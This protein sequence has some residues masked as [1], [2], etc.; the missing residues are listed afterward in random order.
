MT[1][2]H[3]ETSYIAPQWPAPE[4]IKAF[5]STRQHGH[6]KK[7]FD[8]FNLAFHVKDSPQHVV[9]N[10]D[11]LRHD[12]ALAHEPL[13]LNQVHG[14]TV[15]LCQNYSDSAPTAD[16]CIS[17]EVQRPCAILTADCLPILLCANQ[18]DEVAALHA[19]WRGLAHGIVDN[20]I[21]QMR[22]PPAQLLAW[23]GPAIGPSVF[24]VGPEVR[25]DFIAASRDNE[26]GFSP[27]H[28]N[29]WLADLYQ[30]ARLNLQR[31][32]V[33]RIYGGDFCTVTQADYFFSFRR[34][35]GETGRMASVIWRTE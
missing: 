31:C 16:G 30:L 8:S 32:G 28:G 26:A 25:L 14:T 29:Q 23:L 27:Y 1:T 10:R 17:R 2:T 11:K 6:S 34:D 33:Q 21:K 35:K 20:A 18:G 12:W 24:E 13:W 9:R 22:T 4:N 15:I 5:C 7:P 3:P 19:G